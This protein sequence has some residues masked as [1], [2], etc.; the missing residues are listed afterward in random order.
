M[1]RFL[2]L[3]T[4]ALALMSGNSVMAQDS[5]G[6]VSAGKQIFTTSCVAC[7]AIG[8][9]VIGP[10]LKNVDKLRSQAWLIKFIHSPQGM[11]KAGD[12]AAVNLFKQYAPNIML[13]NGTVPNLTDEGIKNIIA[14]IRQQSDSLDK[15]AVSAPAGATAT[16]TTAENAPYKEN[17]VFHRLLFLDEPGNHMPLSFS[18]YAAWLALIVAVVLLAIVLVMCVKIQDLKETTFKE[19]NDEMNV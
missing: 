17:G 13:D 2:L 3:C 4:V 11:Q 14:Y 8:R 1:K 7:H 16:P 10:D 19:E 15:A 6:D 18:D 9:Q 5:T 12:T